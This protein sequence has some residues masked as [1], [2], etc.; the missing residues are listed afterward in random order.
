MEKSVFAG[1]VL[2]IEL[3]LSKRA[4]FLDERP[5][6]GDGKPLR[7]Q[8]AGALLAAHEQARPRFLEIPAPSPSN[9]RRSTITE[10]AGSIIG[11]YKLL[12]TKSGEGRHG[13]GLHGRAASP[14]HTPASALKIVKPG[15]GTPRQVIARFE[16]ERQAWR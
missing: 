8:V 9:V 6:P 5:A 4:S 12:E 7:A 13:R 1:R 10:G 11:H 3:A 14:R 16:S 15:P 2:A